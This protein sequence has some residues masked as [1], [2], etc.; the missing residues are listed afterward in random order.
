MRKFPTIQAIREAKHDYLKFNGRCPR[1][2]ILS[3]DMFNSLLDE[4]YMRREPRRN[5]KGEF[6]FGIPVE[7]DNRV[8]GFRIE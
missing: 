4:I 3:Q 6:L 2:F 1:R 8:K 7:L 5:H